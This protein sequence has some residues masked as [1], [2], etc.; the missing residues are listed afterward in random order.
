M[1]GVGGIYTGVLANE[2]M[3]EETGS[4]YLMDGVPFAVARIPTWVLTDLMKRRPGVCWR[5]FV[6]E[7]NLVGQTPKM[8]RQPSGSAPYRLFAQQLGT[9]QP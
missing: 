2:I 3:R 4:G 6:G 8:L 7:Q 1:R 9:P 5:R